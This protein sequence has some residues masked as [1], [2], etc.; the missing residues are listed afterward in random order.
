MSTE[1][2]EAKLSE[3]KTVHEWL[4]A[5]GVPSK[6]MGKPICLLRRLRITLD[7]YAGMKQRIADHQD[8][9]CR[10]YH[11]TDCTTMQMDIITEMLPDGPD[12][13]CKSSDADDMCARCNC[14]KATRA[15]CS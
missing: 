2:I 7:A 10:I 4:T 9:L 3:R 5:N 12:N 1:E 14:W 13:S 8:A 15:N 6:E 11:T